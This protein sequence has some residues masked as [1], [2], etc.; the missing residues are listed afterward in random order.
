[1]TITP[2]GST[3]AVESNGIGLLPEEANGNSPKL[4]GTITDNNNST[5]K[6]VYEIA[7]GD[8]ATAD[9]MNFS[10]DANTLYY[11][12][13]DSGDFETAEVKKSFTLKIV[14]YNNEVDAGAK[15]SPQIFEYIVNLKNLNDT[16]PVIEGNIAESETEIG[17]IAAGKVGNNQ[18]E[19]AFEVGN[20][21]FAM[22]AGGQEEVTVDF[23]H[24]NIDFVAGDNGG[25]LVDPVYVED[26]PTKDLTGFQITPG[27]LQYDNIGVVIATKNFNG[28]DGSTGNLANLNTL[29]EHL[30]SITLTGTLTGNT[31]ATN[32][33]FTSDATLT[34][35]RGLVVDKDTPITEIIADFS[36]TDADDPDGLGSYTYSLSDSTENN[37]GDASYFTL[38][39]ATGELRRN[40]DKSPTFA[41]GGNADNIYDITITV[42]DGTNTTTYDLRVVVADTL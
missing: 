15:Q 40:A 38:D 6:A 12:G 9:N 13:A 27:V 26:D 23:V 16:A 4:L 8:D 22:N 37:D 25:L 28:I 41:T 42:S 32:A 29:Y 10:I 36:V 31:V 2:E 21:Y 17:Y 7:M 3:E 33:F 1:M 11:I 18:Y 20:G 30:I 24:G 14:R 34:G 39:E 35:T 5:N 19:M